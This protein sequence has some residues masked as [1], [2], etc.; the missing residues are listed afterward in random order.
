MELIFAGQGILALET[1]NYSKCK[2]SIEDL[3]ELT[4]I[5]IN[6]YKEN[7]NVEEVPGLLQQLLR[8]EHYPLPV[9]PI[10]KRIAEIEHYFLRELKLV[11]AAGGIVHFAGSIL[12]MKKRGLWDLPKGKIDAG[13]QPDQTAVR[14]VEEETGV[15]AEIVGKLPAIYHVYDTYGILT[16][17]KTYW[18]GMETKMLPELKP[19]I[20]EGIDHLEFVEKEKVAGMLA[21]S[22]LSLQYLW[23]Q[24]AAE[25]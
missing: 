24:S 20:E 11:E 9:I 16:L 23:K 13:E 18:Y 25:L 4:S 22:F 7:L 5:D 6:K 3:K 8:E 19:Q 14:E 1:E 15:K 21:T 17:K 12:L 2:Q 10:K